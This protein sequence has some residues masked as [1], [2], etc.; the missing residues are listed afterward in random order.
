MS[1][2]VVD[3]YGRIRL[4]KKYLDELGARRFLVRRTGDSIVL[5][6]LKEKDLTKYFDSI[7]VDVEPDKWSDYNELKKALLGD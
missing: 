7:E 2:V 4:P 5:V 1:I 6:P 3:K